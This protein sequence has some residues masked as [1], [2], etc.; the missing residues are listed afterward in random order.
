MT[1]VSCALSKE[2]LLCSLCLDV[3]SAPVT[4]PCGH[5]FCRPCINQHWDQSDIISCPTCKQDFSTR[6]EMNVNTALN[7]MVFAL[8]NKP[9]VEKIARPILEPQFAPAG[10]ASYATSA[11]GEMGYVGLAP[12]R[13]VGFVNMAAP[14]EVRFVGPSAVEGVSLVNMTVPA[15]IRHVN[16]NCDVC[17]DLRAVKSCSLCMKSFCDL[18]LQPHFTSHW[19]KCH[20]LVEPY[21]YLPAQ[22]NTRNIF[23]AIF[24]IF[25]V[26][27]LLF[28]I[29]HSAIFS[30]RFNN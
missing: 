29:I 6:P 17:F 26:V 21:P 5:S 4:T 8:K 1:A 13:G 25:I 14:G 11:Q 22:R 27:S 15:V 7:E 24:L 9:Q 16:V 19:L 12:A 3:F 20:P 28:Y 18:H 23:F 2:Q 10:P 30:Y